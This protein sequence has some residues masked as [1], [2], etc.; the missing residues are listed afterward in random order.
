MR[1]KQGSLFDQLK[2]K[3]T[4]RRYSRRS[5][6]GTFKYAKIERPLSTKKW[7]HLTL[8][9]HKA[10][11]E[12]S[13]LHSKNRQRVEKILADKARKFHVLIAEFVNVGNHLHIKIKISSR[14]SF[15]HFLRAVTTLIARTVT[16]AKKGKPFGRFWQGLAYTRVLKSALEVLQLKGYFEANRRQAGEGDEAREA[17]LLAFNQTIYRMRAKAKGHLQNSV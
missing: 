3:S 6:G 7:I 15:Q 8:K 5:H 4:R 16:G 13:F 17:F 9:S 10:K 2:S 12:L 1:T 14:E 11:G